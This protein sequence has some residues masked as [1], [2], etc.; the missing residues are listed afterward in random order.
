MKNSDPINSQS[1][2][3]SQTHH[4]GIP[5]NA[6]DVYLRTTSGDSTIFENVSQNLMKRLSQKFDILEKST[7]TQRVKI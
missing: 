5:E 6:Q 4:F 3:P 2:A 7:D 1:A